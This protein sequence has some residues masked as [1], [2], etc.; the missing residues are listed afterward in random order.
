MET[1]IVTEFQVQ[2]LRAKIV[3]LPLDQIFQYVKILR[4][5]AQI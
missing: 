3:T 5:T 4:C 2:T 1:L